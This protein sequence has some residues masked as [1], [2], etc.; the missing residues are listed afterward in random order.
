MYIYDKQN[1]DKNFSY[2]DLLLVYSFSKEYLSDTLFDDF[3]CF[4]TIGY[5][6][7]VNTW[8]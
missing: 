6:D 1:P 7:I 5:T 4:I 3:R 2:R 8:C